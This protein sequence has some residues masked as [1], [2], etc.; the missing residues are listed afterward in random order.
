M[1]A[2]SEGVGD[3]DAAAT[4]E[5][6]RTQASVAATAMHRTSVATA[7]SMAARRECAFLPAPRTSSACEGVR[8]SDNGDAQM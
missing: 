3:P 8:W 2:V 7:P 5:S 1:A 6:M 4:A